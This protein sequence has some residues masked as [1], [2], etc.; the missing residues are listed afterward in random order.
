MWPEH[1]V[2]VV[3][4]VLETASSQASVCAC[5]RTCVCSHISLLYVLIQ[6]EAEDVEYTTHR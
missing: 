3:S 2:F 5:V 4:A 1:A 6:T